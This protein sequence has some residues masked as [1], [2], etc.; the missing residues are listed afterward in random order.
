LSF[1]LCITAVSQT[2]GGKEKHPGI[3]D[4]SNMPACRSRTQF[5]DATGRM[6]LTGSRESTGLTDYRFYSHSM[7]SV[8]NSL[9]FAG[10][11]LLRP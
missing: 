10:M 4:V 8:S 6:G 9:S 2:G 1:E 11:R 5:M 3:A 7:N